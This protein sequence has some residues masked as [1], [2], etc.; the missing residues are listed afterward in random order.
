MI[1]RPCFPVSFPQDLLYVAMME[2]AERYLTVMDELAHLSTETAI[3]V[4]KANYL[5]PS[6]LERLFLLNQRLVEFR[7]LEPLNMK[8][9]QI[10]RG[11]QI[12]TS[13]IKSFIFSKLVRPMRETPIV[14]T[15][16]LIQ[17]VQCIPAP[18]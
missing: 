2:I 5:T 12:L 8:S 15:S 10:V 14:T 4:R 6:T 16:L 11:S 17:Y 1:L 7:E 3:R 13:L 9:L 18:F